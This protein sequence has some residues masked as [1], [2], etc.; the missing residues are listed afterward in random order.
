ML[1]LHPKETMLKAEFRIKV[2]MGLTW[3]GISAAGVTLVSKV[4][5]GSAQ[6]FGCLVC[7]SKGVCC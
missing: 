1:C 5:L 3:P 7:C 4:F 2:E 6:A